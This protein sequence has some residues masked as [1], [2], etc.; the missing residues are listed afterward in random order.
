MY[1]IVIDTNVFI[2]ALMSSRGASYQ[3]LKRTGQGLFEIAVSIP[4]IVE[5]EAVALRHQGTLISLSEAEIGDV[6]DYLCSIAHRQTIYYRWRPTLKDKQDDMVLELG[7]NADCDFV[8]TYNLRDYQGSER[9][10]VSGIT[11][12]EFLKKLE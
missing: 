6:I 10:G 8:V 5:Y 1:R 12:A 3:L 11:P 2:S 7:A 4:L 9:F